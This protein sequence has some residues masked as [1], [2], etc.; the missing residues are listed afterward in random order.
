[1]TTATTRLV[2]WAVPLDR[3]DRPGHF[4]AFFPTTTASLVAG[5][6]NAP[7]KT[8]ED[9]QNLLPGPYNDELLEAAA[10]MIAEAL[11]KLATNDDPGRHLDA[12]PRRHEGGDTEQA[13]LL[14]THLFSNLHE[15]EIVPDQDG[16]LHAVG[17]VSYPP[18]ELTADR[19]MDMAPFE[20]WAS[21]PGRP[22]N[23]LHHKAL[24]RNRLAT[25]DRLFPPR[26]RG[27]PSAPRAT[28]SE[29][30]GALVEDQEPGRCGSSLHGSHPD[31]RPAIPPA[32][33]SNEELGDIVLTASG[34]WRAPDPDRLFLPDESPSRGGAADPMSSVHP[35]LASDRDTLAALKELGLGPPSPERRFR[36]V[37][38][39]VLE[40]SG[41]TVLPD[42]SIIHYAAPDDRLHEEFWI[43]SREVSDQVAFAVI[44]E[45]KD[46]RTKQETWPRKLRVRTRAGNLAVLALRAAAGRDR[47]RRWE[48]RRRGDCGH[49]LPRNR[50]IKLLR[51]LG[52][53]DGPHDGCDLSSEQSCMSFPATRVGA[54][55]PKQDNL[56][57]NPDRWYLRFRSSRGVGP[58]DVLAA[59][60]D[61]GNAL[62]TDAVLNLDASFE[63]WAM[64]HT[65][66]NRRSYPE[67]RCKSLAM[68]MLQAHG[69]IR[70]P[71]G[72]VPLAGRDRTASE[73]PG[74]TARIVGPSEDRQDQ[75][76]IRSDRTGAGILRRRTIR[77]R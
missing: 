75:G 33:R 15:R 26:W 22:P 55:I 7:W 44:R 48:S 19:Q 59:L 10:A 57:H 29:W 5:I 2:Q 27:D 23:W 58:L 3:L 37:A 20:C 61:E 47:S 49:P 6:L 28:I 70:T 21:C 13:D 77:F 30:L 39:R 63:P 46:D 50:T 51:A 52:A 35:E 67:M 41:Q 16:N 54:G 71:S 18:K 34:D 25:I 8:N 24:T 64:C 72:I 73:E 53:T 38:T 60:S 31:G 45:F 68:H 69:R 62:Y 56:P 36:L 11:P 40:G 9:R 14:R 65:G 1:M 66:T 43:S 42:G 17:E 4:W 12:L 76:S 74:G 32:I